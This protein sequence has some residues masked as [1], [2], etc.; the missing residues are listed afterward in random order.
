MQSV[1][2]AICNLSRVTGTAC[3]ATKNAGEN[4]L[5][6]NISPLLRGGGKRNIT[7]RYLQIKPQSRDYKEE[8]MQSL[9]SLPLT[10]S[11]K[12]PRHTFLVEMC[13]RQRV[14]C[15]IC[16]VQPADEASVGFHVR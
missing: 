6:F 9:I 5:F 12:Y 14:L 13:L 3:L 4:V 15:V 8:K 10:C 7:C 11:Y 2:S 16:E 1:H